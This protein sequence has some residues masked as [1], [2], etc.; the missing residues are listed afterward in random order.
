M[1]DYV[2]MYLSDSP[3]RVVGRIAGCKHTISPPGHPSRWHVVWGRWGNVHLTDQR[4]G[5]TLLWMDP[6]TVPASTKAIL[7]GISFVL[8]GKE[9]TWGTRPDDDRG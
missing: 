8:Y 2:G 1:G 5:A 3:L 4:F 6:A 9:E 7:G